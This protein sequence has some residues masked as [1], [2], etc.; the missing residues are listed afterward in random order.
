MKSQIIHAVVAGGAGYVI[1]K[2][3]VRKKAVKVEPTK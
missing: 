1:G 2:V 3:I